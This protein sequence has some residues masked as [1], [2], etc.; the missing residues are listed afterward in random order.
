MN[1]LDKVLFP[2]GSPVLQGF[3]G[4]EQLEDRA[5]VGH[6]FPSPKHSAAAQRR[7]Q[8]IMWQ[9]F[10]GILKPKEGPGRGGVGMTQRRPLFLS[11]VEKVF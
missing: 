6:L 1:K 9:E 5:C 8:N 7:A 11:K 2:M 10:A 4:G 3:E